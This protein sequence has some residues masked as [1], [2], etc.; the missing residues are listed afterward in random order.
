MLVGTWACDGSVS[1]TGGPET[2]RHHQVWLQRVGS[3]SLDTDG[4][5]VVA[6]PGSAVLHSEGQEYETRSVA[7]APQ[8][9]TVL[10]L[11]PADVA[12]LLEGS[13]GERGLR[14]PAPA[15]SLSAAAAV[16]HFRLNVL[17]RGKPASPVEVEVVGL[18]L[19]GEL[20]RGVR[21]RG[22]AGAR[23]STVRHRTVRQRRRL[24]HEAPEYLA[25]HLSRR[26]LLVDVARAVGSS[27]FHLSRLFRSE[28][29]TP[30]HRHLVRLRLFAALDR[31]AAGEDDL[32]R[33]ALD[34]GFGSHSHCTTG[35][36][37][38]LGRP[39]TAIRA[40]R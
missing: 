8:A 15:V 30:I 29:G 32:S 38:E 18:S 9:S 19:A 13:V 5:R 22:S 21:S 17:L 3:H 23:G 26:L 36:R 37:R 7:G 10:F 6:E 25:A 24:V 20:L 1:S 4:C 2:A 11:R 39:P 28:T 12:D 40:L 34:V 27:P 16:A 35:F 31:V 14:F 33:L